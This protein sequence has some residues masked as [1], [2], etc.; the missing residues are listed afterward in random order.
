MGNFEF[1]DEKNYDLNLESKKGVMIIHGFSS[2]TFETHPLAQFLSRKGFRVSARNLPGHGTTVEDCNATKYT[3]WLRFVDENLA[4]LSAECD[5]LYV[6]GLS[7]GGVLGLYLASLFPI[8]KLVL[9]AT[10]LNFKEPFKVNYIVPLVNRFIVKQKK[11]KKFTK[12]KHK[13]YSGYDHYPLI[14]LN[15]FRKL[16]NYVIKRLKRVKCPTLYVHSKIDKLSVPSNVDLVMNN[17]SSEIKNKLIVE[18]A[19]HHLFYDSQDKEQIF[20]R[21]YDFING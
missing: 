9:G 18:N 15:E 7:M 19:S 3:D 11:V 10:V 17:I 20:N 13:R 21:I 6:I 4:E 5:E 14:A 8:N 16:N 12:N 2:T 1:F